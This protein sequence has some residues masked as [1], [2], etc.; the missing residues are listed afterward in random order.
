MDNEELFYTVAL[1]M[2]PD[3]GPVI[4]RNLL[5]YAG[6]AKAV[7][8]YSRSRLE[9]VPGVGPLTAERVAAFT[10]FKRV[11]KQLKFAEKADVRILRFHQAD[12]PQRLKRNH[13]AP[14]LLYFRGNANLNA[15]RLISI[16]GTRQCSE[17]AKAFTENF[18]RDLQGLNCTVVSGLAYGIDI[19]AHRAAVKNGICTIGVVA[20]GLDKV[21]PSSHSKTMH[22]MYPNGGMLTEYP[23]ET[24]PDRENFPS[25]N[26]IVAGICDA[27]IVV[28]TPF[29][30]GAMITAYLAHSYNREVFAVPG[31]VGD[32]KKEG[33][34]FLIKKN[35]A[36]LL[37]SVDDLLGYM[38][39]D[40]QGGTVP[41]QLHLELTPSEN[42]ILELFEQKGKWHIDDLNAHDSISSSDL[43]LNLLEL[44]M[45][46]LIRG[47]PGKVYQKVLG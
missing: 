15:P 23:I 2:I 33:T 46:G 45:K 25:R 13:D 42:I 32:P 8:D 19:H 35:K 30:G 3:V 43:S 17:E 24:R 6:S 4:S 40:K 29:K 12:F 44:E 39:W 20:H 37:E 31:R 9:K 5:A 34:H 11:E 36:A 21:Y 27:T 14:L 22:D 47:M 18:V 38:G 26:R 28:E 1:T 7:F 41:Q 16:V 10:D